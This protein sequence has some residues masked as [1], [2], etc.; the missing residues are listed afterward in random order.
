MKELKR[1]AEAGR[2]Y[3]LVKIDEGYAVMAEEDDLAVIDED[4]V[5]AIRLLYA[6]EKENL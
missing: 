1:L 6:Q 2:L 5:Q 3:A 4:P